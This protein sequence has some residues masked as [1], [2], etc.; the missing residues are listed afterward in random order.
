MI[1]FLSMLT[2][3]MLVAGA[4]TVIWTTLAGQADAIVAAL[5][6]RSIRAGALALPAP[7]VRVTVRL[8]SARPLA[9]TPLRAAA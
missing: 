5:A 6:G 1:Y 4:V 2:V 7:R 3:L 9:T 8:P